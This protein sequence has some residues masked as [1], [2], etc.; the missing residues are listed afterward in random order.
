MKKIIALITVCCITLGAF[1][2]DKMNKK[3]ENKSDKMNKSMDN[4]TDKMNKTLTNDTSK[5]KKKIDTT[6]KKAMSRP[7]KVVTR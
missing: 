5:M 6:G 7:H 3:M 2:Q 1:S 4:N